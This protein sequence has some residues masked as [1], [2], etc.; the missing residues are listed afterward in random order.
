MAGLKYDQGKNRL[1]LI[2]PEFIT[3]T[4]K[5]LRHGAEKYDANSWQQI[6]DGVNR[7][8]AALLR[9]LMAWRAGEVFDP[10]SGLPHLYHCA[11]NIM[12]LIY[13]TKDERCT[14]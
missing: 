12:F 5:V 10:D 2:D 3:G 4:G 11:C 6:D 7:Y 14:D 13:L 8:Y 9:H 1:D